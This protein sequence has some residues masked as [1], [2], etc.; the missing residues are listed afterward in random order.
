MNAGLLVLPFLSL[1]IAALGVVV[2]SSL[3]EIAWLAPTIWLV[4]GAVAMAWV[5]LDRKHLRAMFRRKGA[6]YGA[7]SG[8]TVVL[9]I[10]IAL[11]IGT[12]STRARFNKSI[13]FTKNNINTLSEQT[14]RVI[15][16][17]NDKGAET[18]II[19]FF[20]D[21]VQEQMFRDLL[22]LYEAAGAKFNK[23]FL[24][25]QTEPTKAMAEGITQG[26]TALVRQ[27]PNQVKITTF[28]EEKLTNALIQAS[29]ARSKKVYFTKGHGEAE[30]SSEDADG[31]KGAVDELSSH[32]VEAGSVMLLESGKVP[33]D[34]DLVVVPGPKY[35]FKDEEI[36]LL[37]DYLQKGKPLLVM[38]DAMVPAAALSRL[39]ENYGLKFGEDL[40]IMRPDDPRTQLLG[41]NNAIV[42]DFDAFHVVTK[43]FA[44]QSAVA[45]IM[46]STRSLELVTTNTAQAKP[47]I[48][49]KTA[50]VIFGVGQVR[51][52]ADLKE[53]G[54][55]RVKQG[56]FGV[57]GVSQAKVGGAL[58][59][60][61]KAE[62]STTTADL[63]P[64]SSSDAVTKDLRIAA[65]GSS[66]FVTNAGSQH[67][68]NLDLFM[69][70]VNF[71]TQDEDYIA[72]R[73]KDPDRTTI[74]LTS[75]SSQLLLALIAFIYPTSFLGLG[76]YN[77]LRRRRA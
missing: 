53:I 41:Q 64:D 28:T 70:L 68:E 72:I 77:W 14:L 51:S 55:D 43:D 22:R 35:E 4:A 12:L 20:Q 37:E 38:V 25:P 71:L 27:G 30:I 45:L 9:G 69:N 65:V 23:S 6:R 29:K 31:L 50:D 5:I 17:N 39:L 3:K 15:A 73:P 7:S 10:L 19:G 2:N 58:A 76:V 40:L 33:D 1:F 8:L 34:A 54:E 18:E 42:S 16:A 48:I 46:G 32:K 47:S 63:K 62:S 49:G 67:G 26:N 61:E 66:Q 21:E 74:D 60:N 11:G 56:P 13:D 36:K 52:M 24:N 75:A 44:R 59:K 57:I